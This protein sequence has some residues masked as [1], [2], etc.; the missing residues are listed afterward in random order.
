MEEISILA[1]WCRYDNSVACRPP[2]IK[3]F[4]GEEGVSFNY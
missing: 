4:T 3:N 2:E 1:T